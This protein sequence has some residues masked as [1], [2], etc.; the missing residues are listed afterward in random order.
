MSKRV[1]LLAP[2]KNFKSIKAAAKYADSI[3]FG[4]KDFNMRQRSENFS[5]EDLTKISDFCHS[6]DLKAYLATNIL[7]L[8]L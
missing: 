2:A 6:N 7:E 4:I 5:I 8:M 3:Y 1:E